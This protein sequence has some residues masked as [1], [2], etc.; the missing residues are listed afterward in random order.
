[1]GEAGASKSGR[2]FFAW[3]GLAPKQTGRGGKVRL[4]EHLEARRRLLMH[5]VGSRRS[6]VLGLRTIS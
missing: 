4:G 6:P 3:L 5:H 1:M 2:E